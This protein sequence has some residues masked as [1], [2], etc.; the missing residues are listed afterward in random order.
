MESF[1]FVF[2]LQM[3][4]VSQSMAGLMDS[5]HSQCLLSSL[6]E[7]RTRGLFC[8]ITIVVEDVKF[9]AHRNVLAASSGYFQNAFSSTKEPGPAS[10]VFELLDLKSEVFASILNFIYSSTVAPLDNEGFQSLVAAGKRLGIPFLEKLRVQES[11]SSTGPTRAT[12]PMWTPPPQGPHMMKQEVLES[13]SGP[14]ITNAFS[15]T[16]GGAGSNP[17]S[18][19]QIKNDGKRQSGHSTA[20]CLNMTVPQSGPLQILVDHS[21]ALSPVRRLAPHSQLSGVKEGQK[22]MELSSPPASQRCSVPICSRNVTEK[23]RAISVPASSSSDSNSQSSTAVV[24]PSPL[25]SPSFSDCKGQSSTANELP[26]VSKRVSLS[27]AAQSSSPNS[28]LHLHV[29]NGDPAPRTQPPFCTSRFRSRL[30]CRF[31]CRKFIHLKRL[32]SHE[33]VCQQ[34]LKSLAKDSLSSSTTPTVEK[35]ELPSEPSRLPNLLAP[36]TDLRAPRP[37]QAQRRTFP[38]SV[39]KRTYVTLSSLKRH[40]NVHSWRRMYPC[41]YCNKVFALAEYRSKHEIWHT[42]ER[43]YQCIFCLETFMTYYILK[44]HQKTFHGIDSQMLLNRKLP[45]SSFSSGAYPIKLYR[46]LP[47]T[48]RKRRNTYSRTVLEMAECRDQT[49][50]THSSSGFS[51]A[52]SEDSSLTNSGSVGVRRPLFSMPMTFMATPKVAAPV[53]P[54]FP[55]VE[56]NSQ[57][58]LK[59]TEIQ[60]SHAE[61]P[62]QSSGMACTATGSNSSSAGGRDSLSDWSEGNRLGQPSTHKGKAVTYIAKPACAGPGVDNKVPPLCQITVKIGSEAIVRRRIK[63]STLF[64]RKKKRACR[65][66]VEE[67]H[68]DHR[69]QTVG[70]MSSRQRTN[71]TNITETE[72]YD[73]L[74]YRDTLWR[75]YYSYKPKKKMNSMKS[76]KRAKTQ[77]GGLK[78][79]EVTSDPWSVEDQTE[80]STSMKH[81]LS[82]LCDPAGS[83]ECVQQTPFKCER[84]K[85]PFSLCCTHH[86]SRPEWNSVSTSPSL[87]ESAK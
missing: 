21:Y 87:L 39:C 60:K 36:L 55:I 3:A 64:P 78:K 13:G 15:I 1:S 57:T 62:S 58:D 85:S 73:D 7:Q 10:Q 40:E 47:M 25:S 49:S 66:P 24:I 18:S 35:D 69:R 48:F 16:E 51:P 33:Q 63:G 42:G 45:N 23:A 12:S 83:A 9:K 28:Q 59:T 77:H 6:S 8:D 71:A 76:G 75:P 26:L 37:G 4:L 72:T 74:T 32:R 50:P 54:F 67:R 84:C 38:C 46:L 17:I 20:R 56:G 2:P 29:A 70:R 11:S 68:R 80:K 41:H 30:F 61:G 31:C 19:L 86:A 65:S 52:A 44:N 34:A 53:Q 22:A 79:P 27:P 43:R 14:R 81:S 82:S 5:T